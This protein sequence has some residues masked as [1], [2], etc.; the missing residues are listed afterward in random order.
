MGLA[1]RWHGYSIW[2][3]LA[4]ALVVNP[5]AACQDSGIESLSTGT[6]LM[7]ASLSSDWLTIYFTT[8]GDPNAHQY[9]GG[10]DAELA[11]AIDQAR[12][13]VDAA[14]YDLNLWSLR[15]ALLRAHRRGL[16]VRL[17]IESDNLDEPEIQA[18]QR[19]GIPIL[20][21]RREGLMHNKFFVL[22]RKEV[23]T[24]SMNFTTT[25]GYLNDNHLVRLR[26]SQLAEN[27][28]VEFEEM[29]TDDFFGPETRADT[30]FP[31]LQVD[32]ALVETLFSPDDGVARRLIELIT[33]AEESVYFLAFSFTADDIASALMERA[34]AGVTVAGV[35]EE[36]QVTSNIGS[37]YERLLGRG[38]D[39]RLDRNPRNMHHKV[40]LIDEQI[41]AFGSYNFSNS[42]ETRNDENVVIVHDPQA[43]AHFVRE[44]QRIFERAQR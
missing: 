37:E 13:S 17:V 20:G 11:K 7:E 15:D 14:I 10:P 21:D 44:F 24:G 2:W 28:T 27:Y 40:L 38:I 32:H 41:V 23:W 39:V 22:D 8:P 16:T 31:A 30:P 29:Y 35:F 18:L 9:R 1:M 34:Q 6:P 33:G 19:E 3:A 4:A 12:V 25:D 43:A 26:S 5:L 42:A 36:A